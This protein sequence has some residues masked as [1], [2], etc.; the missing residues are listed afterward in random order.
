[1]SVGQQI[2]VRLLAGGTPTR[3]TDPAN[4]TASKPAWNPVN[5]DEN[6]DWIAYTATTTVDGKSVPRLRVANAAGTGD[7]PLFGGTY[8]T[9]RA[10]GA[11]WKP[12]GD[13]VVFLSPETT[14]TCEGDYDHVFGSP[15]HSDQE[16]ALVLNEDREVLS[17]TWLGPLDGGGV[18]VERT[19]AAAPDKNHP[20]AHVVTLQDARSDGSDPRDLGLTILNEDPAADTDTD[21]AKDP[22]FQPA[23]GFDPW[24]ERQN[25]TPDGRRIVVTRFETDAD[26]R[27]DRAD[28][29]GG[30]RRFQ[31]G[32]H[33]AQGPRRDGLGHRPDVLPGRQAP[34]LHPDFAGRRR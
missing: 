31:R 25:Y 15:A 6:R 19:S 12:D 33:A 3:I 34:C 18:V 28:L 5:D 10:H 20:G 11:A 26:G 24:T 23:S 13:G 4:G 14:C 8:A 21:P 9:W 27:M 22:L 7:E 1:M 17:P 32:A 2:Y 30:R 16:P 29:D